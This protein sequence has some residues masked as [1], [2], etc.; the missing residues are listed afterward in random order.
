M[1]GRK[2]NGGHSTKSKKANDRR[3]N[4]AKNL[5]QKYLD[6][7][8][9]Y[10]K[11]KDLMESLY[12]EAKNKKDVKSATLYLNYVLGKPRETK[13]IKLEIEKNL[14]EWLDE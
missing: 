9:D 7:A 14:P 2:N 1:D 6:E 13:E 5:L 3:R 4:D 11:V 12:S 8:V 10:K